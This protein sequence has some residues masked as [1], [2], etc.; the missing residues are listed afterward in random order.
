MVFILSR[1]NCP[2]FLCHCVCSSVWYP[3]DIIS[4]NFILRINVG[5][6]LGHKV[7]GHGHFVVLNEAVISFTYKGPAYI[8]DVYKISLA[9]K[10]YF[11]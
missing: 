5:R 6:H 1:Y 2:L 4:V 8:F 7:E 10:K 9:K 3:C 11:G